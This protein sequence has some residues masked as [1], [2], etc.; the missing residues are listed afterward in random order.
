M[1]LSFS[2]RANFEWH[3]GAM[4]FLVSIFIFLSL[5]LTVRK[6]TWIRTTF[7][8]VMVIFMKVPL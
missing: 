2:S 7:V 1:G 6:N 4:I 8:T 5:E 3:E